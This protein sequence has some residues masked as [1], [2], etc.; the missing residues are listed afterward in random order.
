M[1]RAIGMLT[2]GMFAGAVVCELNA[3]F[4]SI[5]SLQKCFSEFGSTKTRPHNCKPCETTLGQDQNIHPK[6]LWL[7]T[8]TA[9]VTIG[10]HNRRISVSKHLREGHLYARHPHRW[11]YVTAVRRRTQLDWASAHFQWHLAQWR[12][13]LLT[14]E[15]RFSLYRADCVWPHVGLLMS[16][17]WFDRPVVSVRFWVGVFYGQ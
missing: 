6:R 4:S 17:M 13:V 12:G 8:Q 5:C 7:S 9:A 14:D 15:S 10:L 3:H 16:V 2:A 11:L 1:K